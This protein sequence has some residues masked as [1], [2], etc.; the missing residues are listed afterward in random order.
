MFY[1]DL[2]VSM[3]LDGSRHLVCALFLVLYRLVVRGRLCRTLRPAKVV[4]FILNVSTNPTLKVSL[5]PFQRLVVSRPR[6][7]GR[8]PQSAKHPQRRFLFVSFSFA[9]EVSKEKDKDAKRIS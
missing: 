5:K 4:D 8:R 6:K 1:F 9:P 7:G 2:A 3:R